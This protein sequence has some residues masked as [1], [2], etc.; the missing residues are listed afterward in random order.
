L[1]PFLVPS[2]PVATLSPVLGLPTTPVVSV[3]DSRFVVSGSGFDSI[4]IGSTSSASLALNSN[5]DCRLELDDGPPQQPL[6]WFVAA[7]VAET[8]TELAA[9]FADQNR[10]AD[11]TATSETATAVTFDLVPLQAQDADEA[12]THLPQPAIAAILGVAGAM[13]LFGDWSMMFDE[14]SKRRS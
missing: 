6:A 2:N 3:Q 13:A 9:A 7:P 14:D 4:G 10:I 1:V 5:D 12:D 11:P 8:E